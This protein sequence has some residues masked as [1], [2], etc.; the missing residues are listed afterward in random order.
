MHCN[1][2][3]YEIQYKQK[4]CNM[5]YQKVSLVTPE[6]NVWGE[7]TTVPNQEIDTRPS[8][9]TCGRR[10]LSA[11]LLAVSAFLGTTGMPDEPPSSRA[12]LTA[13]AL[14]LRKLT[15]P[16]AHPRHKRARSRSSPTLSAHSTETPRSPLGYPGQ[17]ACPGYYSAGIRSGYSAQQFGGVCEPGDVSSAPV[18]QPMRRRFTVTADF[19][20]ETF[21]IDVLHNHDI[22]TLNRHHLARLYWDFG[23]SLHTAAVLYA[24]RGREGQW[25]KVY[26]PNGYSEIPLAPAPLIEP[27]IPQHW[28]LDSLAASDRTHQGPLA[29]L[30][31][32]RVPRVGSF[33]GR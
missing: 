13:T 21:A 31:S 10:D 9:R 7:T 20:L 24:V 2:Q 6:N 4:E 16:T 14:F 8:V 15:R 19:G 1:I 23:S 27:M 26:S 32:L 25:V 29:S 18:Y 12:T 17:S 30:A 22:F 11:L 28:I 5:Y 33:V 3:M